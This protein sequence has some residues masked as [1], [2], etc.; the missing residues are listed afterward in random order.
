MLDLISSMQKRFTKQ[1]KETNTLS[2]DFAVQ[3]VPVQDA[4]KVEA[5]KPNLNKVEPTKKPVT[6]KVAP[7]NDEEQPL[8]MLSR[9]KLTST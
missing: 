1:K 5:V 2:G 4:P 8:K 6:N 7:V 9:K 3:N